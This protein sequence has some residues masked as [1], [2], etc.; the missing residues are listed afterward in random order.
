MLL[1]SKLFA[2]R[3]SYKICHFWT[4][5][6]NN[7]KLGYIFTPSLNRVKR[8]TLFLHD[9]YGLKEEWN[10][11]TSDDRVRSVINS[12]SL[13]AIN[14]GDS[15]HQALMSFEEQAFSIIKFA[16][17][18]WIEKMAIVGHGMGGRTAIK[19]SM[20]YPQRVN[21]I[22]ILDAPAWDL[23]L[24][25]RYIKKTANWIHYLSNFD[26]QGK[27]IKNIKC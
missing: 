7:S 5:N 26:P 22:V 3:L 12:F 9:V 2:R 16:N 13:D 1:K 23:M 14:H 18:H 6:K 11:I 19:T 4:P 20:I 8:T 24:F 27:S 21:A 25:G 17:E 15:D 10:H